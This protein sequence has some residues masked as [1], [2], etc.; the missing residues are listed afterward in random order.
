MKK[1]KKLIS[2]LTACVMSVSVGAFAACDGTGGGYGDPKSAE[3]ADKVIEKLEEVKTDGVSVDGNITTDGIK[4]DI[5]ARANLSVGAFDVTLHNTDEQEETPYAYCFMRDW[6][7]Y[8]ALSQAEIT[9]FSSAILK[10]I[11]DIGAALEE[12]TGANSL[13]LNLYAPMLMNAVV[14]AGNYMILS[15]GKVTN[16][17]AFKGNTITVDYNLTAY[18]I[19][20]DVK[21]VIDG[22]TATT[23]VGDILGNANVRKYAEIFTE[24][25]SYNDLAT[26]VSIIKN[27]LGGQGVQPIPA[28]EIDYTQVL[29]AALDAID[30][31]L[32]SVT[33]DANSNT[34]D[35]L[36]K[37]LSSDELREIINNAAG[38]EFLEKNLSEYSVKDI[39][40]LAAGQQVTDEQVNGM[41]TAS[42]EELAEKAKNITKESI[43]VVNGTGTAVVSGVKYTLTYNNDHVLLSQGIEG[44]IAVTDSADASANSQTAISLN[45]NYSDEKFTLS[46]LPAKLPEFSGS[47][48]SGD[49]D[50]NS[51]YGKYY[52]ESMIEVDTTIDNSVLG[53]DYM[54]INLKADGTSTM[55]VGGITMSGTY[56]IDGTALY[57]TANGQ[58]DACRLEN[59]KIIME[60]DGTVIT[61]SK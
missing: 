10:P 42:K 17:V 59:G 6:K 57:L 52:F 4:V 33:P 11:V 31:L 12:Q 13:M 25:V 7:V 29:I 55:T 2:F 1:T 3:E 46:K 15:L 39:A 54:V 41:L 56:S 5:S 8:G 50:K 35:Y 53:R 45:V 32:K 22:V 44:N 26:Y 21:D 23:T 19:F 24:L 49:Y 9:D 28:E 16:S 58:T 48:D 51:V 47:G 30:A 36:V 27:I 38:G 37:L 20:N 43:T 14:S 40:S 18:R 34:Y 60:T 61:L